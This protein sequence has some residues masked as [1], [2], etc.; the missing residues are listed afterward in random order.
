MNLEDIGLRTAW[1][2]TNEVI[3]RRTL[4]GEPIPRAIQQLYALL[5]HELRHGPA[6]H[7]AQE[8]SATAPITAAQAAR[9]LDVSP[10]WVRR[11]ASDLDGIQLDGRH[12]VFDR[13]TVEQYADARKTHQVFLSRNRSEA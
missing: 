10:Q 4:T 5:D 3:R 1:R 11:I 13:S 8:T 6:E 2:C 12:W 9:I 7:P